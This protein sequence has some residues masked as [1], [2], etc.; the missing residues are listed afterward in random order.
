MESVPDFAKLLQPHLRRAAWGDFP[1]VVIHA[2]E[3]LVKKH[4]RYAAAKDGDVD[5][6]EELVN[7]TMT[8]NALDR[9]SA[10]I[11]GKNPSLLPIHALETEGV[12]VIPEVFARTLAKVLALPVATGIIQLNRVSHT[13]AGGYHRLAFPPLFDGDVGAREY[14]IVDDFIGQGGTI[15]NLKGFVESYRAQV[16]GATTLTGKSYSAKLRLTEEA[17]RELRRR[18]GDKLEQ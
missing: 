12:N 17:L 1:E 14:F 3:S 11:K 9:I 13:G 5:A 2:E 15:A 6:A 7:E 18:H 10:I 8:L 4:P 16:L